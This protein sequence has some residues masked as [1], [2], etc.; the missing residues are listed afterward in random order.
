MRRSSACS[1][2]CLSASPR[3]GFSLDPS[4]D[5]GGY[6]GQG[7][8]ML[9][10]ALCVAAVAVALNG[11]TVVSTRSGVVHYFE[12]AVFLD[13]Q[14]LSPQLGKFSSLAAGDQLRTGAGRAEILLTPGVF[15]RMDQN[16]SIRMISTSFDDTRVELLSGS[17]MVNA[18]APEAGTALTVACQDWQIHFVDQ[19]IYRVDFSPAQLWVEQGQAEVDDPANGTPVTVAGGMDLPLK[20]ALVAEASV[21]APHDA[22]ENWAH[23]RQDSITADNQI[24]QN[25]QDPADVDNQDPLAAIGVDPNGGGF[26]QFPLLGLAPPVTATPYPYGAAYGGVYN[27]L[28]PYQP[29]FYS[30]YLPGYTYMPLFLALPT[31]VSPYGVRGLGLRGTT[32]PRPGSR[33]LT[34][35]SGTPSINGPLVRPY[36]PPTIGVIRPSAGPI[37]VRPAA[38]VMVRPA[39]PAMG[40][41]PA[42]AAPRVG[43]RR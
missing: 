22:L 43:G 4:S 31:A 8:F 16:S 3:L 14:P 6:C 2:D 12:G 41:R 9:H 19:G 34:P 17:A 26:T 36:T 15:L 20:A 30:M 40:G 32:Y 11:Q 21:A 24:A 39:A 42:V 28:Y 27:P 29:G 1:G 33:T 18:A 10:R 5:V 23:G 7:N 38:P 25:I 13:D 37:T 35:L